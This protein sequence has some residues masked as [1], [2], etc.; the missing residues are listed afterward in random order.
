M[1][2]TTTL[3]AKALQVWKN[4]GLDMVLFKIKLKYSMKTLYMKNVY[5]K[6]I[7]ENETNVQPMEK[8]AY[9][10]LISVVIPVYNVAD[11]MLREC[12][13]SVLCQT[14]RNFEIILVDDASTQE[15]VR[16][17]LRGYEPDPR[18]SVIYRKENGH[19][20]RATNDGI[21]AARGEFVALCDC[22]DLYAPYAL[23]EVAKKLNEDRTLDYIYSDEDKVSENGKVRRDPFFKPDWSPETFMSYMYTCHISVYRKSILEAVGGLRVGFE[24]SQDYDLV[25]RVM[26]Q[27]NRIGHIPKI[28]YHWRMRKESTANS[29]TAKPYIMEST[30]KAKQEALKRRGLDGEL[31]IIPQVSMYRVTYR[32]QGNPLVSIIIPSKDN[33]K[34]LGMCL[35]SIARHTDYA[36]YEI[37]VVD[38]GSSEENRKKYQSLV[39]KMEKTGAA[40]RAVYCYQPMEFNFSRMCNTGAGEA[41]GELFLFLN[42][43]IEISEAV[44][45]NPLLQ[46]PVRQWLSILAGQA[47]VPYAGAV[48]CKLYYPGGIQLQ[49]AGILN[50]KIGPGHCLYGEKDNLNYYYGR[51]LLDYNFCAVTGACLMVERRKFEKAGGFD[52]GLPV[53]YNDVALCFRLVELGYYNTLRNDVALVHHESV[54]RGLDEASAQKEA[55]REQEMRKLYEK[56]PKFAG[57]YDPCYNPNLT[58]DKGDFSFDVN[59]A[60]LPESPVRMTGRAL[61]VLRRVSPD[62][63]ILVHHLDFVDQRGDTVQVNGWVYN[64]RKKNNNYTK[65]RLF[66]KNQDGEMYTVKTEK[67]ASPKL[68]AAQNGN[69]KLS[70]AGF[71]VVFSKNVLPAGKY[72]IGLAIGN[73]YVMSRRWFEV[74]DS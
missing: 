14:Y 22:D 46:A 61:N 35:K 18:I 29:L 51:N 7:A 45:K 10:P 34:V 65:A 44:K 19:I 38:N 74:K 55:R 54:S 28:L 50:L 43:D 60:Y 62:K 12:I 73:L 41:K 42:D 11:R 47:Q 5:K 27:T 30:A 53:A 13:D 16:T 17:V 58:P 71:T 26:E 39:S 57:G 56:F 52:E 49:H 25:L 70:L 23:Y 59:I 63:G 20:S 67:I 21:K 24:G 15:S 68:Q 40:K 6:W 72:R 9:Q 8:L 3:I 1:P 4:E 37:I 33:P 66:L 2:M 48:G 32:P 31:T 69:R 64:S 36:N